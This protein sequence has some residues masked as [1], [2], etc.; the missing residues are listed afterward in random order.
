MTG[1]YKHFAFLVASVTFIISFLYKYIV[2]F[3]VNIEFILKDF[4]LFVL[5]YIVSKIV[6]GYIEDIFNTYRKLL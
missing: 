2:Y 1:L 4:V 5:V 6:F 3:E